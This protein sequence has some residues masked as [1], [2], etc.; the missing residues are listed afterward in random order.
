MI[1]R[2]LSDVSDLI[3][4]A[5]SNWPDFLKYGKFY[6]LFAFNFSIGFV[7]AF[8]PTL[9][10][11]VFAPAWVATAFLGNLLFLACL[12]WAVNAYERSRT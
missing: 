3:A 9:A 2:M 1:Q 8:T 12:I 5:K 7:L 10:A 4:W 11:W 6:A